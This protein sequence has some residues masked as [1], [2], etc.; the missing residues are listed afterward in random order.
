MVMYQ[1]AD[2]D[3]TFQALADPTRRALLSRLADAE[4]LS[5]SE[6]A[7]PFPVTLPAV[8]KHLNV[9]NEAGLIS[10]AKQGR[11][12]TVR[13]NAVPMREALAWLERYQVFW[14]DN[15]DRLAALVEVDDP[16]QG[17]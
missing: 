16:S 4:A 6:L 13:L 2:L 15:L 1:S 10:R 11:T 3:Q 7:E 14:T 5:I 12:V 8:L 17:D 9:L